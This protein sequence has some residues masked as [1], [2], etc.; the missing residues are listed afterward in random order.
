M[1]DQVHQSPIGKIVFGTIQ[2]PRLNQYNNKLEWSLGLVFDLKTSQSMIDIA[3]EAL[4]EAAKRSPKVAAGLNKAILPYKPAQILNPDGTK[5]PDPDNLLFTFKRN[6]TRMVAATGEE[7]R[8]SAP[9]IYGSDG[10][11]LTSF[12]KV[13]GRETT[14]SV[15]FK[16]YVYDKFSVGCQFQIE[17]F[18]ISE[19]NEG[20]SAPATLAPIAGNVTNETESLSILDGEEVL[21]PL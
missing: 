1:A 7:A 14:G 10:A 11:P 13:I 5:L 9:I 6:A 19:L 17:G 21:P 18:Q 16:T 4:K 15:V 8:T 2:E 12:N 20:G 3:D